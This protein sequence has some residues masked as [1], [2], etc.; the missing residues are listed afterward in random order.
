MSLLDALNQILGP[1][2]GVCL[3]QRMSAYYCVMVTIVRDRILDMRKKDMMLDQ[4]QAAKLTR[5]YDP[6]WGTTAGSTAMFFETVYKS[7]AEKGTR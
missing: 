3:T 4:V 6:R 7:L 1:G 5:D 2:H